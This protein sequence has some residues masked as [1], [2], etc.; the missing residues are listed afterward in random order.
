VDVIITLGI[1]YAGPIEQNEA[2]SSEDKKP[3]PWQ[4]IAEEAS[5]EKDFNRLQLLAEELERSLQ[6]RDRQLQSERISAWQTKEPDLPARD[7]P[8]A[9]P[10]E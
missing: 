5:R 2:V 8:F 4:E 3:R 9:P 1:C 7:L 6:E 10:D